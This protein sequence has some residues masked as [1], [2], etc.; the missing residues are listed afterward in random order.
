MENFLLVDG[1]NLLFQ[2]FYGMP[3]RIIGKDGRAVQA[4]VGFTGTLLKVIKDIQASYVIVLFDGEKGSYRV[5]KNT[6][7]KG[8]RKDYT[9]A[10]D[11]DNPFLQLIDIKRV[12]DFLNVKHFEIVERI[13]TDDVIASYVA[14][15]KNEYNI[16]ILS[17]DTDFMQLVE[18]N[19][20]IFVYRGKKSIIYD[21]NAV[22]NKFGV[23]PPYLADYKSLVG[24]SSDNIRGIKGVGPKTAE[25]LIHKFGHIEDIINN[26]NSIENNSIRL[27]IKDN[28]DVLFTNLNLIKLRQITAVPYEIEELHFNNYDEYK[29]MEILREINLM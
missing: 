15:F 3:S 14:K 9:D 27:M 2:M 1:H 6:E 25:K 28:M 7:Y 24:D 11:D 10:A 12:L 16:F 8:N 13:E 20:R 23:A 22:I 29:T 5:D 4:V 19:V 21:A 17:T 26:I 18:D